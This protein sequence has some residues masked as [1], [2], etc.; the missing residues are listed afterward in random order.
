MKRKFSCISASALL[1]TGILSASIVAPAYARGGG[2]GQSQASG[3]QT[4]SVICSIG[5][6]SLGGV[7][8]TAC[9]GSNTGNDTG[10]KGTLLSKL[11]DDDLFS[12]FVGTG[13]QW[14]LA[15]KSDGT[16]PFAITT[17]D[18][19]ISSGAWGLGST[20]SS[21][22]FVVSLKAGNGYSA[23]LFKDYD[24]SQ[25][26]TGIFNTIGVA[27]D[28]GGNAG[29]ALSHASLFVSNIGRNTPPPPTSVP[30]PGTLLGLGLLATGMIKVRRR[31]SI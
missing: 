22:T 21:N 11:N 5:D 14:S 31:R 19:E 9:D 12:S 3:G 18:G 2:Q 28:G 23:Y 20:L 16:N 27:L 24:F 17:D 10:D 7:S 26:L 4:S 15:G 1:V 30:E 13:V 25:G 8:A 6:I 29:K